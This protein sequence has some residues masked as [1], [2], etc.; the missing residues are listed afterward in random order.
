MAERLGAV[1]HG[2]LESVCKKETGTERRGVKFAFLI[3]MT[4]FSREIF[5]TERALIQHRAFC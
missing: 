2:Y 4:L 5:E 1:G 3:A